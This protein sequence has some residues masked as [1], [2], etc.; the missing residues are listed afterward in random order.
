MNRI[1]V[2]LFLC[3]IQRE[4][5]NETVHGLEVK[6]ECFTST[7]HYCL[8]FPS[9]WRQVRCTFCKF[10]SAFRCCSLLLRL[11]NHFDA[12]SNCN[13]ILMPRV[14]WSMWHESL[15]LTAS[16]QKHV[17]PKHPSF[18]SLEVCVT[19]YGHKDRKHRSVCKS[20]PISILPLWSPPPCS[21]PTPRA[22]QCRQV[23]A[24][25]RASKTQLC[26]QPK[27]ETKS[28]RCSL[29]KSSRVPADGSE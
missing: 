20:K 12:S 8:N 17:E 10:T 13:G 9:V 22:G 15:Y 24:L 23:G 25:A 18:Q 21:R 27:S 2:T 16:T 5:K 19:E 28:P 6:S 29:W 1:S 4:C 26:F 11:I 3:F 14:K 7:Q